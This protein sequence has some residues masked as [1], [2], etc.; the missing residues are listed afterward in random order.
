MERHFIAND[1]EE[2]QLIGVAKIGDT[3]TA[4]GGISENTRVLYRCID[5]SEKQVVW[6][7]ES[8]DGD[9]IDEA[10]VGA[11]YVIDVRKPFET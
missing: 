9:D 4:M 5:S 3:A 8:V 7:F 11:L 1:L 2:C 6:K 10:C